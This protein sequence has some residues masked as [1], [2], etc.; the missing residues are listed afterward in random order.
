MAGRLGNQEVTDDLMRSFSRGP[1]RGNTTMGKG[2]KKCWCKPCGFDCFDCIFQTFENG[3]ES[4]DWVRKVL[5]GN[6]KI[7]KDFLGRFI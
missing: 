4:V 3:S 6:F 1:R 2:S 7:S 5:I